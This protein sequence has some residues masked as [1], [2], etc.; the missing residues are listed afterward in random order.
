MSVSNIT[1]SISKRM[2]KAIADYDMLQ[3]NDKVIV[4]VSG[5]K[6]SLTLLNVMLYRQSFIPINVEL[7]AVHIDYGIPKFPT[8]RLIE[9]FQE[10][11][12]RYIVEK[13]DFLKDSDIKDTNC[14]WC[15]WNR[16]KALFEIADRLGFN[17]IALAHHMD[18]IV[19]TILLNMFFNGEIGAMKPKQE[20]FGGK[21]TIIRPLAYE[22]EE[23]I[24]RL[25][26]KEGF[27]D[28][29]KFDCP[30]KNNS[31]REMVKKIISDIKKINP[32]VKTN[33][34]R[35][36]KNIKKDYLL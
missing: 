14:F 20:L 15:S 11:K 2:G 30:N 8:K 19:E 9:Y 31:K 10:K 16:R 18:D 17:K 29:D 3:D 12:I 27:D 25:A 34:F 23:L 33:I 26:K 4:A 32:A 7:L 21:I 6:D 1:V 24:S 28:I 35:S 36:L 5:G 13:I 22:T